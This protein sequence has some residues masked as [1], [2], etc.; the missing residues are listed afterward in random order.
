M[1][2]VRRAG[3]R[4]SEVVGSA[5]ISA[6]ATPGIHAW[7]K[8]RAGT[9]HESASTGFVHALFEVRRS[10]AARIKHTKVEYFII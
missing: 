6:G 5:A 10:R 4:P 7:T 2:V 8:V 1:V 9:A 3:S